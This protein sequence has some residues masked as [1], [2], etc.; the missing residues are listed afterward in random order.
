[1][2]RRSFQWTRGGG[3]G[4][5]MTSSAIAGVG[6]LAGR[7]G[8]EHPPTTAISYLSTVGQPPLPAEQPPTAQT[9]IITATLTNQPTNQP[10]LAVGGQALD[11][12]ACQR[13][14]QRGLA[15]EGGDGHG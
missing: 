13:A 5:D 2:G 15:C 3:R 1:M 7:L 10:H 14:K 8:T 9:A 4:S 12:V 11:L 6:L